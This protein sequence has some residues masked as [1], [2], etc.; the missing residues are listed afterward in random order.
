MQI[1]KIL[2]NIEDYHTGEKEIHLVMIE[3][4]ETGKRILHKK[5]VQGEEVIYKSLNQAVALSCGDIL[6]EDAHRLIVVDIA[7]CDAIVLKPVSFYQVAAICYEIGNKHLPL[8]YDDEEILVAY[9]APLFR[10]LEAA[11]FA[12]SI[13]LRKLARPL[14]TSVKAHSSTS[15]GSLFSKL[16]QITSTPANE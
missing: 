1:N 3:W 6:F 4:H 11:A 2:G 5:T 7:P 16:L 9:E 8:F 14:R 12:P 15:N 10:Q 13:Q